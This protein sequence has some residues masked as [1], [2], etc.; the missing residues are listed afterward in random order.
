[1]CAW[2]SPVRR[3]WLLIF[4]LAVLVLGT[5]QSAYTFQS[6]LRDAQ[7]AGCRRGNVDSRVNEQI[8]R[9]EIV[10]T[11]LVANDPKQPFATRVARAHEVAVKSRELPGAHVRA[12]V[13]CRAVYPAPSRFRIF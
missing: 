10:A 6:E 13:D 3:Q 2:V 1:M 11:S 5:F 8:L 4:T 9:A 7:V 12:H